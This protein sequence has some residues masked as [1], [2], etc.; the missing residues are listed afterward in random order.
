MNQ[1]KDIG[2]QKTGAEN[3]STPDTIKPYNSEGNDT[4]I[5]SKDSQVL[6][7]RTGMIEKF[8]FNFFFIYIIVSL[9]RIIYRAIAVFI[10]SCFIILVKPYRFDKDRD[11][12][13][14]FL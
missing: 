11:S 1:R 5:P 8:Y 9:F 14:T 3:S 12:E 7:M 13:D 6:R 4:F 2:R 10:L